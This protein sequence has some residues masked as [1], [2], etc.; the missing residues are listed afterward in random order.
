MSRYHVSNQLLPGAVACAGAFS[1]VCRARQDCLVARLFC[2]RWA[3]IVGPVALFRLTVARLGESH[4]S[5]HCETRQGAH[6]GYSSAK[7]CTGRL[8]LGC[9]G[10]GCRPCHPRHNRPSAPPCL[11]GSMSQA[12]HSPLVACD[13]SFRTHQKWVARVVRSF[14]VFSILVK[15]PRAI[16]SLVDQMLRQAKKP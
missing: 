16:K 2:R 12:D 1:G 7:G 10:S 13:G 15:N 3:A 4:T 6:P 11:P 5:G 8:E 14:A 9:R